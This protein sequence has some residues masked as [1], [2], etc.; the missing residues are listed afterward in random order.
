MLYTG[1]DL[2]KNFSVF[3][4]VDENGK[5]IKQEK[6]YNNPDKILNYFWSLEEQHKA[7]CECTIGWYWLVDLLKENEI[8]IIIAH[9]KM[10][11]AIAYAKVKT[12]RV[13]SFI[14]A[15]LLRMDFIPQANIL[16]PEIRELRDLMRSRLRLIQKRTSC[17][18][19]VHRLLEKFNLSAPDKLAGLY[20]YQYK[21]LDTQIALLKRQIKD[22]ERVIRNRIVLNEQVQRILWIPGIGLITAYTIYLEIGDIKRFPSEKHFFS[23][24][25]VVP[26]ASDSGGKTSHANKKSKAGNK[27]LKIA[28]NDAALEAYSSYPVIRDFYNRKCR[29]KNKHLARNLVAKELARIVYQVL[30]K[31]ENY[32]HTFKGKELTNKKTRRWPCPTSPVIEMVTE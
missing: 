20:Q 22:L 25:R 9:S 31:Q 14:L 12:D 8:D 6:I 29:K 28:F 24:A 17:K 10:L 5:A 26:G 3:T 19:S 4:T 30:Y 1:I 7:V 18:N 11:K 16:P 13:D 23:Y 15:Q 27:Y 32:N 21:H 2:H